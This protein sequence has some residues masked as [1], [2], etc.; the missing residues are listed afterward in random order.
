MSFGVGQFGLRLKSLSSRKLSVDQDPADPRTFPDGRANYFI[1]AH[2]AEHFERVGGVGANTQHTAEWA[3][4]GVSR[5]QTIIAPET[6]YCF[7]TDA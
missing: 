4:E 5:V 7:P 3:Y 6:A 2:A 1:M